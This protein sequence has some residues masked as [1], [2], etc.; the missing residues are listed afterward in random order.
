MTTTP[1]VPSWHTLGSEGLRWALAY[2]VVATEA[3]CGDGAGVQQPRAPEPLTPEDFARLPVWGEDPPD[4]SYSTSSLRVRALWGKNEGEVGLATYKTSDGERIKVISERTGQPLS[5]EDPQA[6]TLVRGLATPAPVQATRD[7]VQAVRDALHTRLINLMP[8][9]QDISAALE[10][11]FGLPAT[12]A[13]HESPMRF[14]PYLARECPGLMLAFRRLLPAEPEPGKGDLR[15]VVCFAAD[16]V[17]PAGDLVRVQEAV[18]D[19]LTELV[20]L[21]RGQ[22]EVGP[23][24]ASEGTGGEGGREQRVSFEITGLR[25]AVNGPDPAVPVGTTRAEEMFALIR[26]LLMTSRQHGMFCYGVRA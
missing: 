19:F 25:P 23:W 16:G 7:A 15:R 10:E 8:S 21:R 20:G 24:E 26:H 11:A 14:S 5:S 4:Y 1:S 22:I 9:C 6:F 12:G 13:P 17:V 18:V 3:Y 2:D